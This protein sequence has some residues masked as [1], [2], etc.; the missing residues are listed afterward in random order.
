MRHD[1]LKREME[2]LLL[3]TQNRQYTV[4]EICEKTGISRRSFYYYIEFFEQAG[5]VVERQGRF[6]SL[7]RTSWFFKRLYDLVQLTE[8]EVVLMRQLIENAGM[9]SGRLKSLHKKLDRF[10]DFKILEDEMLQRKTSEMRGI[11]YEA[12]KQ[13]MMVR[14]KGYSSPSSHSVSDRIVEPFLFLNN[15]KDVRCYELSSEMNKTFRLSRMGDVEMLDRPWEHESHHRRVYIDLFSFSGEKTMHVTLLMGQ[16]SHNVMLEEYPE[17]AACFTRQEDGRW[18][19]EADVCSYLGI[20]R[21]ILGLYDDM[22]VVGDEGLREYLMEKIKRWGEENKV[23][24][25]MEK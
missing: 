25:N 16:L 6:Y 2:L 20:G 4:E 12:I 8:D 22:E 3:L 24:A 18:L 17:S 13:G 7:S 5:F 19:F 21:F 14:I 1:H 23:E 15:N 9:E 10:Y 11:I